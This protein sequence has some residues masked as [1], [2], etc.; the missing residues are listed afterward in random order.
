[1]AYKGRN[2]EIKVKPCQ[3]GAIKMIADAC[4]D[5]KAA[6]NNFILDKTMC[7]DSDSSSENVSV[8]SRDHLF[9]N[10]IVQEKVFR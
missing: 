7:D 5:V 6:N 2:I 1:M 10:L 4:G 8:D 9:T 3:D